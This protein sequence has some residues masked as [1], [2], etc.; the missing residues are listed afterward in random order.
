VPLRR[1][2]EG[3]SIMKTTAAARLE[4]INSRISADRESMVQEIYAG[5]TEQQKYLPCKY[6]YD[7]YGSALFERICHL[8]EYYQ[9]RTE[10]S[11]LRTAAPVIMKNMKDGNLIE[12]GSGANWKIRTLL[13]AANGSRPNIRY[14]P[15]DVC[16][17]ALKQAVEDLIERYPDLAVTGIIADFHR[18]MDKIM[19]HGDKLIT[20]FGSTIGNFNE[21]ES[22]AFLKNIAAAMTLRDRL[23]V[24]M[25]LIKPKEMLERAYNDAQGITAAF[26]KNILTVLNHE[27]NVAFDPSHFD[28]VAFYNEKRECIEMHLRANRDIY[29]EM[30]DIDL[31]LIM[32]RGETIFTEICR[33]FSRKK[34]EKMAAEAGFV[35]TRWFTD[36]QGWFALVELMLESSVQTM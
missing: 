10:L 11:I 4:I 2:L 33:K 35:I 5:L 24:G 22:R 6:F 34:V 12:L 19:V 21:E 23:L 18:D 14:V 15:V 31:Q 8:P 1:R 28:H 16:E 20:F 9:T 36:D 30:E 26:N 17:P 27:L 32:K 25:D 13:D 3:E 7:S 29:M